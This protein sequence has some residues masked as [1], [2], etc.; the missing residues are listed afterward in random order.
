MRG[1]AV[2]G[3]TGS[4]GRT[5]LDLARA[6]PA[7]LQVVTLA[8]RRDSD[9]LRRQIA[10]HRPALV[11]VASKLDAAELRAAFPDLDVTTGPAGLERA[12]AH[13]AVSTVVVAVVGTAGLVP[14]VAAV[15]AGK[16]VALA[17][18]EVLVAAGDLVMAE[19][20]RAN[21][22]LRPVD[23]EHSALETLLGDRPGDAVARLVLTAS[24]GPFLNWSLERMAGATVEQ[25]LEHPT[26]SM[27]AKISVDSATMMNKGLEIIEAHHLFGVPEDTIEVVIHPQSVVHAMVVMADGAV[28]AHLAGRD[29]RLPIAA[30]VAPDGALGRTVAALD[31]AALGQLDFCPPDTDRFPAL[32]LARA[33]LRAGG[34]L[35]TVLNAANEVAVDAFLGRRCGFTDIAAT[36]D[37][38]LGGWRGAGRPPASVAEVFAVDAEARRRTVEVLGNND[39]VGWVAG[40]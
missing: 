18:K 17:T 38:V 3:S 26:W 4:V 9:L 8:A 24:G 35:P 23:S 40:R 10:D 20:R 1:L 29:M 33:A 37:A 13:D 25:A 6:H 15:A 2:L 22:R 16:T 36:V 12:A 7:Q 31:P 30:A 28:L 14:T 21:G 39:L 32:G 11:A 5:T 27:G 34:E 19:V